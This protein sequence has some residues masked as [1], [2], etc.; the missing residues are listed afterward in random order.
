MGKE[1]N[2][3]ERFEQL[4]TIEPSVEWKEKLMLRLEESN[5]KKQD[6]SG[7]R[8]AIYFLFLLLMVNVIAYS[9]DWW[10]ENSQMNTVSMRSIA[11]E[12]LITS[13]SS[14]F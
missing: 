8:W 4:P 7:S 1:V 3:L 2:L 12:Y 9:R 13:N 6:T 14:K 10:K 5:M 11:T